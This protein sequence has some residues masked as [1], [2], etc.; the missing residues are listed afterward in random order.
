MAVKDG[1]DSFPPLKIPLVAVIEV[2]EAIDR[3]RDNQDE[4][5][6]I[7]R[8]IEVLHAI[9]SN[10]GSEAETP[11]SMRERLQRVSDE[12]YE[13]KKVVNSKIRRRVVRRAVESLTD[14]K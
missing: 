8:K 1:S 5:L 6:N 4:F 12:L 3:V 13:V 7:A 10:F 9:F 11:P 2:M 14:A